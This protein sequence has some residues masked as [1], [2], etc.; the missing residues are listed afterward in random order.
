MA[1]LQNMTNFLG[2][3]NL[4][5]LHCETD[6]DNK[7]GIFLTYSLNTIQTHK[8]VSRSRTRFFILC[9]T[10]VAVSMSTEG[11]SLSCNTQLHVEKRQ[12]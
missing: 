2:L 1:V 4:I 10:K 6:F 3:M 8:R 11:L 9:T 12:L 7:L 5:C